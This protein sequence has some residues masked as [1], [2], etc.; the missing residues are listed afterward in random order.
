[1]MQAK[2]QVP[3]WTKPSGGCSETEIAV[4]ITLNCESP[5]HHLILDYHL[6]FTIPA[7]TQIL[8][9]VSLINPGNFS[10]RQRTVWIN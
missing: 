3:S 10:L 2:S 1:M 7:Q 4:A 6:Y 5:V 8:S 9:T